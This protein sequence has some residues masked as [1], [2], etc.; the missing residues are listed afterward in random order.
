M[1]KVFSYSVEGIPFL[2]EFNSIY[3]SSDSNNAELG[4]EGV[5]VV[6]EP[7]DLDDLIQALTNEITSRVRV[8]T[9]LAE[10]LNLTNE[11][12][13]NLLYDPLPDSNIKNGSRLYLDEF[14]EVFSTDQVD[15][16]NQKF[17]LFTNALSGKLSGIFANPGT[18]ISFDLSNPAFPVIT[19]NRPSWNNIQN[20]PS[21]IQL[22]GQKGQANGYASLDG[23]G[24]VPVSQIPNVN[25]SLQIVANI[26]ERNALVLTGNTPVLVIDASDDPNVNS[27]HAFYVYNFANTT[28]IKFKIGSI[29]KTNRPN[30]IR[31]LTVIQ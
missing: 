3:I 17:A 4:R 18:G 24:K 1:A 9:Q 22:T 29:F 5:H 6:L 11:R 10:G 12:I 19:Q 28:W 16:L 2:W 15:G 7:S 27:G 14:I 21:G 13:N 31:L 8:D 23:S 26:T 30:L 20:K 25:S